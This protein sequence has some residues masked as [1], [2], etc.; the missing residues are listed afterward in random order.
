M[1]YTG[2]QS[3]RQGRNQNSAPETKIV[4]AFL[5][6]PQ[7]FPLFPTFNGTKSSVECKKVVSDILGEIEFLTDIKS[8]GKMTHF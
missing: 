3:L 2:F 4:L 7:V 5:T 8:A 6:F 1:N